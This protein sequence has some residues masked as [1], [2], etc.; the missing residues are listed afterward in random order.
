MRAL[1]VVQ[2]GAPAEALELVDIPVPD[3]GPGEVR[4][5]V[6]AASVNFGDI[7]RCRG[8]VAAVMAEPPFTLGMDVAGIR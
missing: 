5:A 6:S 8:G 2:H 3:P 4:I 7:A 1:R